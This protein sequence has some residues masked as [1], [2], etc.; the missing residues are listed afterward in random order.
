MCVEDIREGVSLSRRIPS[1]AGEAEV[2]CGECGTTL[3]LILP[4]YAALGIPAR[5]TG[6]GRLPQRPLSVYQE[7]LPRH[8]VTLQT[9][10]EAGAGDCLPLRLSGRLTGG[11]YCLPGDI[12]S[13]F[14]SGLL[15]ALPLCRED[16]VIRLTSPLESAGYVRM[17][18]EAMR[19]GGRSGGDGKGRLAHSW[20]TGLPGPSAIRWK[21]TGPKRPSF[22]RRGLWA[23]S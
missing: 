21:G 7:L 18:L 11:E 19:P 22:W 17:T 16:S 2:D 14:V 3:R 10:P 8:G 5:F 23:V 9:E 13:Q 4:V 20:R 6:S 15:L 1:L 12:S